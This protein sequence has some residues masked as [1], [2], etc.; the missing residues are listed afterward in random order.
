MKDENDKVT[1]DMF[2]KEE[3]IEILK[4]LG[5]INSDGSLSENYYSESGR[6]VKVFAKHDKGVLYYRLPT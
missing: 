1:I 5:I 4:E 2:E 6:V 3:A